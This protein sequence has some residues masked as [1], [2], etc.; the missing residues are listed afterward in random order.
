MPPL[1]QQLAR[2]NSALGISHLRARG[3]RE[4]P[5]FMTQRLD[6]AEHVG[7]PARDVTAGSEKIEGH[8]PKDRIIVRVTYSETPFPL[9]SLDEG[10][11][12]WDGDDINRYGKIEFYSRDDVVLGVDILADASRGFEYERWRF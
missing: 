10:T 9:V 6:F 2:L 8:K 7:F 11:S 1:L 4:I 3:A 12:S 5:A